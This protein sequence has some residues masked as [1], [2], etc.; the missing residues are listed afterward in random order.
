MI[1]LKSALTGLLGV[2]VAAVVLP[3]LVIVGIVI[4]TATHS[5]AEGSIGGIP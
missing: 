5:S 2:V 1:Y 3:M 4:D